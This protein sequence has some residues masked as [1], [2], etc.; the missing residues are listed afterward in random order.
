M[1]GGTWRWQLERLR[2]HPH[3]TALS[4]GI[5][6]CQHLMVHLHRLCPETLGFPRARHQ[7]GAGLHGAKEGAG[8]RRRVQREIPLAVQGHPLPRR[9]GGG[10]SDPRR[11]GDTEK[12][13]GGG[14]QQHRSGLVGVRGGI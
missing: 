6:P 2:V 10:D 1:G 4:S 13:A 3:R 8:R 11:A 12:P 7:D 9:R 14:L 5:V